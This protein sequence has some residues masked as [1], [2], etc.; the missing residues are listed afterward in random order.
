M[1][2]AHLFDAGVPDGARDLE[3]AG[4]TADSRKV[5]PGFL[6][7]ALQGAASHGR[8]FTGDAKAR[9]AVAVLSAGDAAT[10]LAHVVS[11]S[12]RRALALAA[13]R[14]WP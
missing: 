7:A 12:P 8:D 14:F 1:K 2:L 3:I 6:F 4:I 5:A 13:A 10:D 9:G 11:P